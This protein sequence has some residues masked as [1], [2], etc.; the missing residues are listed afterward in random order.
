MSINFF[1]DNLEE[2]IV[3]I[4]YKDIKLFLIKNLFDDESFNELQLEI[5]NVMKNEENWVKVTAQESNPRKTLKQNVSKLIDNM[6]RSLKKSKLLDHINKI[7]DENYTSCDF[8]VWWD[9]CDYFIG[10]HSDNQ[11]IETSIQLYVMDTTHYHLGTSFAYLKDIGKIN[12]TNKPFLTLPYIQ[13][14]G[15]LF[16]N[17]KTI[18]HGMTMSVPDGFDRVSLY[19]YIN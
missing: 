12:E 7:M 18:R 17:T 13:N 6:N 16:K 11:Q 15:Y 9:T 4:Q 10:W 1:N 2:N 14:S 19:F 8:K 5:L 3:K